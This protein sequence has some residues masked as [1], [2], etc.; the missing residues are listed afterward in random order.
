MHI[1]LDKGREYKYAIQLA[2][3]TTNN[4]IEY[5]VLLARLMV[6]ASLEAK[7]IEARTYS[8]V[9]RNQ[10]RG[11]FVAKSERLRKYLHEVKKLPIL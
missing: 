5:E 8:Q 2:F 3:K 11:E 9:V 1:V 10:V 4:E 7:E 6:T